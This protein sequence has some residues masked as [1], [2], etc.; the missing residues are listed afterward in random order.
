MLQWQ[1]SLSIGVEDIDAQHR[2]ILALIDELTAKR[3]RATPGTVGEALAFLRAY[4]AKHF[5]LEEELMAKICYPR[6]REHVA[7]HEAF[8]NRVVSFEIDEEFGQPSQV[9]LEAMLAFLT[10]WFLHH[11]A[12]EDKSIGAYLRRRT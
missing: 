10:E 6:L 3:D 12:G 7:I 5:M 9:L 8:I 1:D 11:I 4:V 2:A